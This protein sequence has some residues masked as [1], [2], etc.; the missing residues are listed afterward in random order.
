M[1]YHFLLAENKGRLALKL[2]LTSDQLT[3]M[4]IGLQ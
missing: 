2:G 4:I 1:F 3:A